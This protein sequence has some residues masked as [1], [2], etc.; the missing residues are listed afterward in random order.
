MQKWSPEP[1]DPGQVTVINGVGGEQPAFEPANGEGVDEQ[2]PDSSAMRF[3][4]ESGFASDAALLSHLTRE[5]RSTLFELVEIDVAKQYEARAREQEEEFQ[6]RLQEFERQFQAWAEAFGTEVNRR[7]EGMAKSCI[8]LSLDLAEKIVRKTVDLDREVLVRSLETT[9]YKVPSGHPLSI[10]VNPQDAEWLQDEPSMLATLNIEK[11][12]PDRRITRGGCMVE[13]G[14]REWDAT[15]EGQVEAL[16]QL[17]WEQVAT[18]SGSSTAPLLEPTLESVRQ[19][20]AVGA[21]E[22]GAV[23]VQGDGNA[24]DL[25]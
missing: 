15:L 3:R 22:D 6:H 20:I 4:R 17:V 18:K 12:I 24:Q 14:G 11:V 13:S 5:E 8:A 10:T 19:E 1:F 7:L 9:L 21:D 2:G 25:G 23:P 16:S